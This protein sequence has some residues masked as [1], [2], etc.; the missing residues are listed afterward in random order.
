MTESTDLELVP[1]STGPIDVDVV[2]Q[3][4]D[5]ILDRAHL[6]LAEGLYLAAVPHSYD[7]ALFKA[8][9]AQED[10]RDER[11]VARLARFSFITQLDDEAEPRY[12]MQATEREILLRRWIAAEP[13]A[14]VTA[15]RRALT[16]LEAHPD[17]D[18]FTQ[19]QTRL[20]HL[21]MTDGKAGLE[22][23]ASTFR[24]YA[25]ER[26]LAAA[27]RLLVTAAE[28]RTYLAALAVPWLADLDNLLAYL[29]ARLAQYRGQWDESLES[30]KA[31]RQKA[32][33]VPSLV[34]Y[35][36]RA[37][38]SALAK[39]GLYVEAIEQYQFALDIFRQQPDSEAEQAF[40]MFDL[41]DAHVGLAVSA[42]GYREIIS[43][44]TDR[45]RQ[46]L[47]GLL[48]F[49]TL[50]PLIA[51]L[52]V[53][54][55]PRVW[56]PRF[57]PMLQGLDWIIARLFVTGARWY[58]QAGRLLDTLDTHAGRVQADEKL[59]HLYLAMGDAAQAASSF[60]TLL[61]GREPLLGEY[62]RASVRAGLGRALLRLGQL[63]P[64]LE[65]LQEALPVIQVYDDVE[66]GAQVQ[67][68]LAEA[69]F[70]TGKHVEALHQFRQALRLYQRQGDVV[71]ATEIA[72]RLQELAQDPRLDSQDRETASTTTQSL[73]RRQYL[74]RFHHPALVTFRR[75]GLILLALVV[76][77]M[78]M[79]A[80]HVET[81][82]VVLADIR[83]HASPLLEPNP[84]Y[85][86]TLSQA[87]ALNVAPS[88]ETISFVLL[89]V[90][91]LVLLYLSSYTL[92]G[93]FL[94]VRTR[95][96]A[97]Q[98]V[99]SEAVQLDLQGL[100]VGRG[101]TARRLPWREI[102]R[103]LVADV[104]F[105][106]SPMAE[107]SS[108]VVA[109]PQERIT[110]N[111]STAWYTSLKNHILAF[112]PKGARVTNLSYRLLRSWT[113]VL[114]LFGIL[115][116][117]LF[118]LL[119]VWRP[120]LLT[121]N[122]LG[123]PYSA[124]GLYPYLH[125]GTF[126]PPFWWIVIQ[127]LYIQ[128]HLN[129]RSRLVWW[130]GGAGLLLAILRWATSTQPWLIPPDIYPSLT[131]MLLVGTTG[132]ALWT[133]RL[134]E[135][136]RER[137]GPHVYPLWVRGLATVVI[138]VILAVAGFRLWN[139]VRVHHHLIVGNSQRDRGLQAQTL[140]KTEQV[141]GLLKEA[142]GTYDRVLASSPQNV[143]VLNS[144]AAIQA[145][146]GRYEVA[147]ADYG[148][149]L[150]HAKAVGQIYANRALANVG[151]GLALQ[152]ADAGEA[153]KEKFAA[154]LA[155]FDQAIRLDPENVDYYVQR[156]VAY[157]ALGQLDA[158]LED[159]EQA[160]AWDPNYAQALTGQGWVFFQKADDLS[161]QAVQ[162]EDKAAQAELKAASQE[163]FGL[164][165]ES[166]QEAAR[167]DADSPEIWLAV[168]YAHYRLG[169]Y[170]ATLTA[171]ERAT[172]LAPDDPVMFISRGTAHWLL[173]KGSRCRSDTATEAEKEEAVYHLD[174]A[175]D[176][177]NRALAL[178]PDDDYTYRTRAQIEYLLA[179]C[180]G[181]DTKQMLS[182][183]IAS[184]GEALKYKPENDLYWLF[185]GRLRHSL[186][187]Y[188][189]VNE[190]G[191]EAKAQAMLDAAIEGISR[192]YELNPDNPA[193]QLWRDFIGDVA[194][195]RYYLLRGSDYYEA[196]QYGLALTDFKEAARL[197]E[198]ASAAFPERANAAF[199]AG[200]AALA[201][202]RATRAS[203]WYDEG[204]DR[205]MDME[206]AKAAADAQQ[207]A[208]DDLTALL[209]VNPRLQWL[210][211]PI[212]EE[213]QAAATGLERTP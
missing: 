45:W 27:D 35:V 170:E 209:E 113:G 87:V 203:E 37:Y 23:L 58:R 18:P 163:A 195:G 120:K 42:R 31:L 155:D 168:G 15:H 110:I 89:P 213:L 157:H 117:V 82:S 4:L 149:A 177:L 22:H 184:Y 109:T 6:L 208:L 54:F 60:Q 206:E 96:S 71:S 8:L 187:Q 98:A 66:L 128:M 26:W 185:L 99:Q 72:E 196:G 63:D 164:A 136:Q 127:P 160:L 152:E 97:V 73:T 204:Q 107:N 14:F 84:N 111:G 180:P 33:L 13:E 65:Q 122:L 166:F 56:H 142:T 199:K 116:Q 171:W 145:Q 143:T 81:G 182:K 197:L 93:I 147:V 159:F 131:T 36:A 78:P 75:T 16:F 202:G 207:A 186:G 144:R 48:S 158:A 154:G 92:L 211:A 101:E 9:R 200:L 38:G 103:L 201:Q 76:F 10:G 19:A 59:A 52:S 2:A 20:Y 134:P 105:L 106:G 190:P 129:P 150:R 167:H 88:F 32:R 11:L 192:A 1:I 115:S 55:G 172:K 193:N 57:W 169:E 194:W 104:E 123:T 50:L 132:V 119:V 53:Y 30:L 173:A 91:G 3:L 25:R 189:F 47:D 74:R 139:Q 108:L 28:V 61:E 86:P 198:P 5:Q 146:L 77:F 175:I 176:D 34:P 118:A 85:T 21:L 138:V 125:L 191:N 126:L 130:I 179:S 49:R 140:G 79:L 137:R 121:T 12:A 24:A 68:L 188:T 94:I 102:S 80:T 178:R 165:L 141:T 70:E 41:G 64:A 62:R 174:L 40:T 100:M 51:Y 83:F 29:T 124:A 162:T 212:L 135:A 90:L 148:Q 7:T 114:Y 183:A 156:G 210:S 95:L 69:L 39:T 43:P 151:W 153:A 161:K 17:P 181:Y 133:A 46:W 67:G 112:L 44:P 205:V